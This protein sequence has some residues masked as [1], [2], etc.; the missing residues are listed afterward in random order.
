MTE[1]ETK[2][3][4][5]KETSQVPRMREMVEKNFLDSRAQAPLNRLCVYIKQQEVMYMHI[6]LYL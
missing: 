3:G 6:H 4:L 1:I 2:I 5:G